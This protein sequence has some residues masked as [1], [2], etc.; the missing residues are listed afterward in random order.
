MSE[1][2]PL[3]A[4]EAPTK[5]SRKNSNVHNTNLLGWIFRARSFLS[6]RIAIPNLDEVKKAE[7]VFITKPFSTISNPK[8]GLK[9]QDA[10]FKREVELA[11]LAKNDP[12]EREVLVHRRRI[13]EVSYL[14][15]WQ[16]IAW[17]VWLLIVQ[18]WADVWERR[19]FRGVLATDAWAHYY[20]SPS[21]VIEDL[22]SEPR[23]VHSH[24]QTSTTGGRFWT[25][26][27]NHGQIDGQSDAT[28]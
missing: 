25:L 8:Q 10:D 7:E 3:M 26:Q 9:A 27:S 14:H 19:P 15:I 24:E 17:S 4:R 18:K 2:T 22:K 28:I 6:R 21:L 12:A 1:K 16:F 20:V 13:P 23:A 11:E 5:M